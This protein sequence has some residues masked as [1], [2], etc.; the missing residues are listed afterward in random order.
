MDNS[1]RRALVGVLSS[2]AGLALVVQVAQLPEPA[3]ADPAPES[4]SR[5]AL[6]SESEQLAQLL[7]RTLP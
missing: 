4:A 5:E 7:I 3:A 2:A 1:L 6:G